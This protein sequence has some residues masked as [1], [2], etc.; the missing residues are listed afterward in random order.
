MQRHRPDGGERRLL[1]GHARRRERDEVAG[2]EVVLRVRRVASTCAR[3]QRSNR[4]FAGAVVADDPRTDVA[5]RFGHSEAVPDRALRLQE[6][7]SPDLFDDFADEV[8][9][10]RRLARQREAC[11]LGRSPFRPPAHERGARLDEHVSVAR[12]GPRNLLR[13]RPPASIAYY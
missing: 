5:E 4:I 3:D 11:K 6:T 7:V 12:P 10:P 1:G 2:D 13:P 8:W 9:T